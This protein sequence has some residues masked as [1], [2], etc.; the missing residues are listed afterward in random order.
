VQRHDS[1]EDLRVERLVAGL[2]GLSDEGC[3]WV[4]RV[5]EDAEALEPIRTLR[6]PDP[7]LLKPLLAH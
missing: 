6:L 3:A 1:A 5:L 4:L 7:R 2:Y